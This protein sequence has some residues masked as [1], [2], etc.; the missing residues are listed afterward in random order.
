MKPNRRVQRGFRV[1]P[2]WTDFLGNIRIVLVG[3]TH[4][5]NI[6]AVARVMKN[7]GLKNLRLV[8]SI[9]CGPDTEAFSMS[10]GA[11]DIILKAERFEQVQS[12]ISD[13]VMAVATSARLGGK[14]TTAKIP[15]EIVGELMAKSRIGLVSLVFGRESRGLTNEEIK[16]CDQ[17][18]II[19]TD[20]EFASMNLAQAVAIMCHEIFEVACQPIG[21]KALS[22]RPADVES[23]EQ[24][25]L[26][27]ENVLV[28]TGFI[29]TK[30][31]LE[32]MRDVRRILNSASM[33]DRDVRI[34]RGIFRKI[35]NMVRLATQN[36]RAE[37]EKNASV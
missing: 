16:L 35:H 4:P 36:R 20:A 12:A 19:P 11:Y 21:V 32:M 25:F 3:T 27:I 8:S 10:S 24:M 23:R 29:R 7:M 22:F 28:D 2:D 34:I 6:G 1:H 5:G 30:N 33:D 15:S 13:T 17:H 14:R 9:S 31:S 37:M 26:H 18:A